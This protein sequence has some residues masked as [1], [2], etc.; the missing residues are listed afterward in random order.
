MKLVKSKSING[1]AYIEREPQLD[2]KGTKLVTFSSQ[3][4]LNYGI[5]DTFEFVYRKTFHKP[6][7][8]H[9]L[10][11]MPEQTVVLRS[12]KGKFK[13]FC[14]N[15]CSSDSETVHIIRSLDESEKTTILIPAGIIWGVLIYNEG[16]VLQIQTSTEVIW[17]KAKI[18]D[19]AE[20][21]LSSAFGDYEFSIA[22]EYGEKI[23]LNEIIGI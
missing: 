12:I 2:L 6:D 5:K 19:P 14:I 20:E 1:V 16:S 18:V 3:L 8:F 10:F 13:I 23:K 17:S 4:L 7:E 21:Q 22:S 9:G 15:L 11:F